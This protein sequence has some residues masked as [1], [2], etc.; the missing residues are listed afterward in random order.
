MSTYYN[1]LYE[2]I[3]QNKLN[4]IKR[5]NISLDEL[6]EDGCFLFMH[7]CCEGHIQ[8]VS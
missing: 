1:I 8:L 4:R 2:R 5:M 3:K 6:K 7:A